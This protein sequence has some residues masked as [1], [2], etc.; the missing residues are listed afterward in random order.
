MTE[1]PPWR[2]ASARVIKRLP[3]WLLAF[4][5]FPLLSSLHAQTTTR[6]LDLDGSNACVVLP[7]DLITNDVVTVEGW[8]KWRSFNA[9][10]R[11]FDFYGQRMQ[12]GIQNREKTATLR[13]ERPERD[14]T[15]LIISWFQVDVSG[16]LATNEWCHVAVVVRTNSAKLFFNG[17][18]VATAEARSDW[19]A[20]TEPDRTNYLGRSAMNSQR[21]AG[22]DPDFNGQMT[23]IRLWAG[24]RSETQ[25]RENMF[26]RLTG[27]EPGL[28][29]L[30][31]FDDPGQPGKDSSPNAHHGTLAGQARVVN[32]PRPDS[33]GLKLPVMLF[34]QV[35]DDHKN[36]ASNATIRVLDGDAEIAKATSGTNG[37]FLIA[38]RAEREKFDVAASAGDLGA[39]ALGVACPNGQRTELNFTLTNAVSIGGKVAD[40]AGV[41]IEDVIVQAVRAG[42]PPRESGRLATPG[43]AATT[44]STATNGSLNYRFLNLRPGEYKVRIHV[45]EGQVE[46][47]HGEALRV[48]PGKTLDADFK[49][50]PFRKG[51]WRHYSTG[52]GIPSN[53]TFD[54]YFALDGTLWLATQAGV[55][56][57]DGLKFTTLSE[58]DGLID[59]RVFCI[60]AGREGALWFGTEKGASLFDPATG[61]FQ[62]FPSGTNGLSAGSVFDME[63]APDGMLW[64]RTRQGLSRFNG[65][66]FQ[67]IPGIPPYGMYASAFPDKALAVDHE[68][69]VWTGS[70]QGGLWR[71]EGTNAV[72]V[73][74]ATQKEDPDA[75]HVAPDGKVWFS[76]TITRDGRLARFD[77][78]RFEHLDIAESAI[79]HIVL[80]IHTTAEGIM[81]LGEDAGGVTRFD[82][83]RFTFTRFG[84]GKDAPS[85]E[86]VKIRP[87]PDGALWFATQGGLYRYEEATLVNYSKADGLPDEV[88]FTSAV[89]TDGTVWLAGAGSFLARVK[90][91]AIEAGESRFVD[92][93][94]EGFDKTGVMALLADAKGGLWVGGAPELGGVYYHAS[95]AVQRGEKP[96]R[97]PPDNGMLNSGFTGSFL[98]EGDKTMWVGKLDQGLHKFNLEDLWAGK[99][100]DQKIKG[101]TNDAAT[102]YQD[103][104]GAIWTAAR[105]SGSHRFSRVKGDEVQYFSTES[106]G[107]AMPSDS[108]LCFQEGAD[109]LLY[110]GTEE[111]VA[112][113]DGTRFAGLEGT[114]HGPVP[115]GNVL[116]IF[117]DREDV[118]WFTS[119]SGLF[120]Y[121]GVTLS[122]LD[123]EDGMPAMFSA[124]IAQG[125]DGAYWIG[126]TKGVSC[127]RPNRQTPSPPQLVVK[128]DREYS[129]AEKIPAIAPGQLVGFRFSAV[130]FRTQPS[131]RLYR[132]AIVPRRVEVPPAKRDAAWREPTSAAQFDWNP[133]TP[134]DYTFFVQSIDRDLNYSEPARATLRIIT[135]W[136]ANAWIMLPGGGA[137]L[138]LAGWAL[139]SG[140]LAIRRKREADQ[141]REQMLKQERRARAAMEAKNTQLVAAKEAAETA[142]EQ[143][144]TANAAKSEFLANMSH[145]IRTPMN[146]ILGFSELLRTQLAASKE[147]NYLD[148]ISSS[149]RTLLTLINDI[150]DLSKIEAGKLELQYEPVSIARVVD[151]IQKVFSIKAGEKGIKLLTEIDPKLP[152]GLML[153]EVRL[154]QVLFNVVGNALKFTEKGQV[155]IRA[156]AD[157]NEQGAPHPDPLPKGEGESADARG[158]SETFEKHQDRPTALPLPGV[159]ESQPEETR[160]NLLLEVSDTGIGIPKAQQEHIFGAF[161]QVAGQS[162]RKFGGTGL[163]LTITKRLTEMMLG[164]VTVRSEPGKGS[165]FRFVFP[166]VA[167]TELAD[168]DAVA[169]DGQ[170]DFNQFAPATLLVADDVALNRALLAG[171]FEGT[172]HKLITATNGLEALQQAEKHRPDVILMDMRMPEL[173]GHETTKRLKANPALKHIPVIAVTASSFREEEARARKICD[174][175]IRKPFNRADLIAELK[176]FLPRVKTQA[177][178][179]AAPA[180]ETVT[181]PVETP[182]SPAVLARRPELLAKLREE[183]ARVW[184]GLCK[185]MAMDKVEQ[186]ASRLKAWAAEGQWPSLGAYAENLDQQVQEFDLTRLP[187]TLNNF[188]AILRSVS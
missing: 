1:R 118:L 89:T 154:R 34:G 5:L 182:V 67:E 18:P 91:G 17:V 58:R 149:G 87:G 132:C 150:L 175:F 99:A 97:S 105:S 152:R 184:P 171:Y 115:R 40:F 26:T 12:F 142:R 71:V 169:T 156:W 31:N 158:N 117:R 32:A 83:V 164:V 180:P 134:G 75:L 173:D 80:A 138:G 179:S 11:V 108:V 90:T 86:V 46:Y 85:S 151:E 124:T 43:L 160:V 59:N 41:P 22:R 183:E 121:D 39:W 188:P 120:R 96:F 181:V 129:G 130:D 82:P 107:G 148:A 112:R 9:N 146:A 159:R 69:R 16:L 135:P 72:E 155:K 102:I 36:T 167:I 137:A 4:L 143:A 8:F 7:S 52:N 14:A 140:S 37:N 100:T 70:H 3:S 136:Y 168:S 185:T 113:Y 79:H 23:E 66:S 53:R 144:E 77:G 119:D 162:T 76:D 92:A 6:V 10:S 131:R 174:G 30:W 84:G 145:E 139:V 172:A 44:L 111:G 110:I 64:L 98:I 45:P 153:D 35:Y 57:F 122:S 161:S 116:Q 186:F 65:Q 123:E 127:Y 147:R 68:G 103:S 62:N 33:G 176:R 24:E 15:G 61:R 49:I 2:N 187:Q 78:Q 88:T 94:T 51:R 28:I 128:T 54:L 101:V 73:A 63:A 74:E 95:N 60:H 27:G 29:G 104:R 25:I 42:A 56:H 48:E 170:G 20:S 163:G 47:H 19:S 133:K 141:L 126:T 38:L 93:R 166:N 106:T 81:W 109:G 125:H 157:E 177:T 165:T 50:A 21:G 55:S 178:F 13:F 114:A